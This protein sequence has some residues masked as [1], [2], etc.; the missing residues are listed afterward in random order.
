MSSAKTGCHVN[1]QSSDQ[2]RF[3]LLCSACATEAGAADTSNIVGPGSVLHGAACERCGA[4]FVGF[5]H[6]VPA[7]IYTGMNPGPG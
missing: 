6:R 2:E 4:R 3:V 1:D 7:G 5:A